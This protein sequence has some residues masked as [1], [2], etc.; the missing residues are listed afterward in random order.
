M[1]SRVSAG[2]L[3]DVAKM[4]ARYAYPIALLSGLALAV[5]FPSQGI[6]PFAFVGVAGAVSTVLGRGFFAGLAVGF[7]GGVT[8]WAVLIRWLNLYLGPVP[9]LAL[10]VVMGVF[11][12]IGMAVTGWTCSWLL[13]RYRHTAAVWIPG[14]IAVIWVAREVLSGLGPYGGFPWGRI[15]LSQADSPFASFA[16][17]VGISGL[18]LVIVWLSS[19]PVVLVWWRCSRSQIEADRDAGEGRRR[20]LGVSAVAVA[21]CAGFAPSWATL[22]ASGTAT[23]RVVAIQGN[24]KAGLFA[25]HDRGEWLANHLAVT[26]STDLTGADLIVWPENSSDIDPQAN[27]DAYAAL[28]QLTGSTGVPLV[29]G[30]IQNRGTQYFNSSLLW[31]PDQGIVAVY[32]KRHPVPFA[33]YMPNRSFFEALAPDLVNLVQRNYT[34]GTTNGVFDAGGARFGVNICFD[35]AYDD[36]LRDAVFGGASFILSQTNNADFGDSDESIQQLAIARMQAISNGRSVVSVSTV[37]YSAIYGP[38]GAVLSSVPR[39]EG[40]S[41][42]ADVP[43]VDAIAPGTI[44]NVVV[45]LA[46]VGFSVGV[47]CVVGWSR[48]V[49]AKKRTGRFV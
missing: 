29:F 32:D 28:Q 40:M 42:T 6:W 30:T 49:R 24:A 13:R 2:H 22:F 14:V 33:E 41:L 19:V 11:F 38:D 39:F 36:I 45:E 46:A 44:V 35:I 21:L 25:E 12:S 23:T 15:A 43:Q 16:S 3:S 17:W 47:I 48:V 31:K 10:A 27:A 4:R 37:G 7:V 1:G 5:S 9:W 8:F 20:V 18:S 34:A 26:K